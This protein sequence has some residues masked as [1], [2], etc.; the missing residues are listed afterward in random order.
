MPYWAAA[1]LQPRRDHFAEHYLR[2]I[3]FEV[4]LPRLRQ[5]RTLHGRKVVAAPPLFPGYAF[6]FIRMQWHTAR[7]APGVVRLVMNG[8]DP[9]AVPAGV[10]AAL[11]ARETGG[12]I[13]LPRPPK[14]HRGDR[15]RVLHGPLAGLTGL[16][17]GMRPHERIAVLLTMLG[18]LQRVELAADA[19]EQAR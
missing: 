4:Y 17:D 6:V 13:E 7:W 5:P 16:Y 14:F 9:A 15:V 8:V 19:V 12:L 1:Q 18:G 2:Q 10:I 11:K 3:G